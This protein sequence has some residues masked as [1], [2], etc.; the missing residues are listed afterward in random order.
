MNT[1]GTTNND[2]TEEDTIDTENLLALKGNDQIV[3]S[4]ITSIA[5]KHDEKQIDIVEHEQNI[6]SMTEKNVE[7]QLLD[8]VE[9]EIE[10]KCSE[11]NECKQ[12]IDQQEDSQNKENEQVQQ[13]AKQGKQIKEND[14]DEDSQD[15]NLKDKQGEQ[16]SERKNESEDKMIDEYDDEQDSQ[17]DYVEDT[18]DE[19]DDNVNKDKQGKQISKQMEGE[20]R[21][22]AAALLLLKQQNSC[23]STLD[24][25]L[26]LQSGTTFLKLGQ[27]VKVPL[28]KPRMDETVQVGLYGQKCNNAKIKFDNPF[29]KQ[30]LYMGIEFVKEG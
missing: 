22:S 9:E 12:Q 27:V 19:K 14:D 7:E 30:R 16:I 5:G 13:I 21:A 26:N 10:Q 29:Y 17:A 11:D 24:F 8:K 23:V 3:G 6:N 25:S 20:A 18:P 4:A 1:N 28:N 2:K 15:D